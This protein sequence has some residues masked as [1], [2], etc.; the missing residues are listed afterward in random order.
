MRVVAAGAMTL[1]K[2]PCAAP[3]V[4]RLRVRPM[5]AAFAVAYERFTGKPNTP[6]E[7]VITIRP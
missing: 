2:M 4:V 1:T 6:A 7:L 3:A 5:T